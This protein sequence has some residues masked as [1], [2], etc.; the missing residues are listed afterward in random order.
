MKEFSEKFVEEQLS[1]QQIRILDLRVT[2]CDSEILK[3]VEKQLNDN[4]KR[5]EH[6]LSIRAGK[7]RQSV[8]ERRRRT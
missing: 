5:I 2:G 4:R 3:T 6:T 8:I 7:W 1:N